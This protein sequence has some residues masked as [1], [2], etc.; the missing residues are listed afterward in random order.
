MI[1]FS[2]IYRKGTRFLPLCPRKRAARGSEKFEGLGLGLVKL[3]IKSTT[4]HLDPSLRT[5]SHFYDYSA[6]YT[7]SLFDLQ[8]LCASEPKTKSA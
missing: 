8:E 3:H 4:T 6:F 1:P 5:T 2:T 7:V